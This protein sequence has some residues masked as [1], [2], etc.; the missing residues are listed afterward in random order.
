MY[1]KNRRNQSGKSTRLEIKKGKIF[2]IHVTIEQPKI[3]NNT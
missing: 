2:G 1:D 3:V